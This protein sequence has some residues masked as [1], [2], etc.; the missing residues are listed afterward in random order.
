[1]A[2]LATATFDCVYPACGGLCCMNGRPAVEP[3]EQERIAANLDKFLPHLQ[4]AARALVERSGFRSVEEKE[5]LPTL[6]LSR[7]WCVFFHDGCVLHKVG[8]AEGDRFRY[9]PWRCVAF[10][11]A[12]DKRS[13]DWH[14]RQRGQRGEAWDL[15]CLNPAE[16]R[17]TADTT[18]RTE[19]AFVAEAQAEGR[20]PP[21]AGR[22]HDGAAKPVGAVRV[23]GKPLRKR[24]R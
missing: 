20:I 4:P 9:K 8:A 1:V 16:S 18:L 11:L 23:D 21:L 14:V 7:G 3:H 15:F 24:R 6:K 17:K 19:V 5:G 22:K 13:G 2:N 12:R 10:P